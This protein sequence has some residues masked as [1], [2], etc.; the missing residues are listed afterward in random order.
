MVIFGRFS[1]RPPS[2]GGVPRRSRTPTSMRSRAGGWSPCS[3]LRV[4]RDRLRLGA[5][6]PGISRIRA[7][8]SACGL[9]KSCRRPGSARSGRSGRRW[10]SRIRGMV[11]SSGWLLVTSPTSARRKVTLGVDAVILT[12]MRCWTESLPSLRSRWRACGAGSTVSWKPCEGSIASVERSPPRMTSTRPTWPPSPAWIPRRRR[13]SWR[14]H[15]EV[16][17]PRSFFAFEA[18]E[19]PAVEVHT[20][21]ESSSLTQRDSSRRRPARS[22]GGWTW[23]CACR[24]PKDPNT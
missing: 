23:S 6:A 14:A 20:V 8:S 17:S 9:G 2:G 16:G 24:P 10:G 21:R 3:G 13:R 5:G 12:C 15:P 18:E 11:G 22:Q 7:W 19:R 4:P 1:V